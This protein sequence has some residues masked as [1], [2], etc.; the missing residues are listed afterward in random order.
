MLRRLI[1]AIAAAI[2]VLSATDA[3][4]ACV[5]YTYTFSNGTTADAG[6]V[7]SNF[8][9][10]M[11]CATTP[12]PLSTRQVLTSGTSATYTAPANVRQLRIRMVGGGGG[13]G[14]NSGYG[15]SGSVGGTTSF[16]SVTAAGGGGSGVN[17]GAGGTGGSGSPTGIVRFIGGGGGGGMSVAATTITSNYGGAGGSSMFGGGATPGSVTGGAN[18]GGGGGGGL[19]HR[20]IKAYPNSD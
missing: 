11:N 18:T 14:G 5:P 6:Q 7:N 16:N 20:L 10:V 2:G 15:T 9:T 13:G 17:G 3:Y 12:A 8:T 19:G 1:L 4:A